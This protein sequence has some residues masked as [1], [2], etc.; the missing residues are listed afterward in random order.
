MEADWI[1]LCHWMSQRARGIRPD[2]SAGS[3]SVPFTHSFLLLHAAISFSFPSYFRS[4]LLVPLLP[5]LK[6][7]LSSPS[8]LIP[9][10]SLLVLSVLHIQ[11]ISRCPCFPLNQF[12]MSPFPRFLKHHRISALGCSFCSVASTLQK[13]PWTLPQSSGM[14]NATST[15]ISCHDMYQL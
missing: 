2:L 8:Q 5:D 3:L 13:T 11:Y 7:F 14:C 4:F 12:N 1:W 9:Q 6:M 10:P 15:F